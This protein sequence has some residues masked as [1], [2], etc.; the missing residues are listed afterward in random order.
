VKNS[1]YIRLFH[2]LVIFILFTK[3]ALQKQFELTELHETELQRHKVQEDEFSRVS[4]ELESIKMSS[5]EAK[6]HYSSIIN[7]QSAKITA[8]ELEKDELCVAVDKYRFDLPHCRSR[9][10]FTHPPPFYSLT[11]GK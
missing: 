7:E 5:Q 2:S 3:V 8:I 10:L 6:S 11:G 1:R 4:L 9:T